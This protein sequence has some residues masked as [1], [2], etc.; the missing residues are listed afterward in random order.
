MKSFQGFFLA[1]LFGLAVIA[2]LQAA[3]GKKATEGIYI[4]PTLGLTFFD[5]ELNYEDPAATFSLGLGYQ[6]NNPVALELVVSTSS[7][8][9]DNRNST[10][11]DYFQIRFDALYNL[12]QFK[13]W[14]P[15]L[16]AGIGDGTLDSGNDKNDQTEFN[17]GV[18]VT[19]FINDNWALRGD[20]RLFYL[21]DISF[22]DTQFNVGVSY[23]FSGS[24]K[25]ASKSSK[26]SK[27][28]KEPKQAS[29][30]VKKEPQKVSGPDKTQKT[31][32]AKI[33]ESAFLAA[34]YDGDGVSNVL[35][36]CKDT[37]LGV[38]VDNSGC[39][40]DSDMDGVGDFIDRCPQTPK[41]TKVDNEG[42]AGDADSD[43]VK[44]N[45][46]NC[47]NTMAGVSVD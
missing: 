37:P 42:C 15:Y 27:S 23:Y 26:S 14:N 30:E 29:Q 39:P 10:E 24:K 5:D 18:G 32:Q 4:S 7:T 31:T 45:K 40:T 33:S 11:I 34:D 36:R 19:K 35:D 46:D 16:V 44:D 43:G 1:L 25:S 21:Y 9:V 28:S 20:A 13:D 47:P 3:S 17:G 8:E 38:R 2:P 12:P 22:M 6:F 41:G